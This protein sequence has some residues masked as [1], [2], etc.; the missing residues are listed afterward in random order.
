MPLVCCECHAPATVSYADW[1]WCWTCFRRRLRIAGLGD[2]ETTICLDAMID[3]AAGLA[4]GISQYGP[5][6]LNSDRRDF[7]TEAAMEARDGNIYHLIERRRR[8][9]GD[10]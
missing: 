7:V 6:D 9:R 8:G 4:A 1:D 3:A 5:L 2:D 10:S